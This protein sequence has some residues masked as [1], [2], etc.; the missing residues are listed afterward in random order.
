MKSDPYEFDSQTKFKDVPRARHGLPWEA[1]ELANLRD[2]YMRGDTLK[3]ICDR[4]QRPKEGV[5]LKLANLG[6]IQKETN[7]FLWVWRRKVLPDAWKVDYQ[8]QKFRR[9]VE[10]YGCNPAKMQ[11]DAFKTY[12][13][14]ET[15]IGD[16]ENAVFKG[17]I[18]GVATLPDLSGLG[19]FTTGITNPTQLNPKTKP[20]EPIMKIETKVFINDQDASTMTDD[21]IFAEIRRAENRIEGL[22]AIKTPTK[23][24]ADN[25]TKLEKYAA[26]LAK[27]VD[28]R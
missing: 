24:L 10:A 4:M 8:S 1:P 28:S 23:K 12:P 21:Q 18:S 6:L 9:N 22:K 27:Y 26:D 14:L 13:Y 15:F 5:L 20:K 7:G 2:L 3:H 17:A 19:I 25:I 16:L 11:P